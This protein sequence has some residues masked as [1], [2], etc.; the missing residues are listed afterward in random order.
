MQLKEKDY[1]RANSD[2]L[3]EYFK[4]PGAKEKNRQ[5]QLLAHKRKRVV[6]DRCKQLLKDNIIDKVLPSTAKGIKVFKEFE[7]YLMDLI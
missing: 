2:R 5:A 4:K 6:I 3:K 7:K 1:Q